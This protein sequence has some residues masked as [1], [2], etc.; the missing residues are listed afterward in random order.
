MAALGSPAVDEEAMAATVT[1]YWDELWRRRDLDVIDELFAEKYVRHSSA[2]T[3]VLRRDDLKREVRAA[4]RLLHD[5]VTTVDDEVVDG[6]RVWTRA[7]AEGVNLDTG[8]PSVLTWLVVQRLTDGRIV[9]SW[10]ATMPGVD[11]RR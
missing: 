6:D 8:E 7:T 10:N 5:A 11:W 3:R 9:E 1:R 4:W 2:G